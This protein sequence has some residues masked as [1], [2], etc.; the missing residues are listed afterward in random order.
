MFLGVK[1]IYALP[2]YQLP[3]GAADPPLV[4][5][6]TSFGPHNGASSQQNGANSRQTGKLGKKKGSK[7][8]AEAVR[9]AEEFEKDEQQQINKDNLLKQSEVAEPPGSFPEEDARRHIERNQAAMAQMRASKQ[10]EPSSNGSR[11]PEGGLG[12]L[13]EEMA[14]KGTQ[15]AVGVAAEAGRFY[16]RIA[17]VRTVPCSALRSSLLMISLV[18]YVHL[19]IVSFSST[20]ELMLTSREGLVAHALSACEV[21]CKTARK[22]CH[23]VSHL[24]DQTNAGCG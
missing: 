15:G 19:T 4:D 24:T 20:S 8:D 9:A 12:G 6:Q 16:R 5:P 1:H 23:G 3:A 11:Q 2:G 7:D 22:D 13:K 18:M 10:G 21:T 14:V 17:D